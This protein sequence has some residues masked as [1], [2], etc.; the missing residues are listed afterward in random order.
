MVTEG[1]CGDGRD[2]CGDGRG[3]VVTEG[4]LRWR[5]GVCCDEREVCGDGRA[6][7]VSGSVVTEGVCGEGRGQR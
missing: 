4:G 2:L 3:Y 7:T 5:E 1:V 6:Y